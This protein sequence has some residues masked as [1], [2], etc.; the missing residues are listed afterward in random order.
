MILIESPKQKLF[1]FGF[2]Y[3][4]GR[5]QACCSTVAPMNER[6]P[7]CSCSYTVGKKIPEIISK[8]NLVFIKNN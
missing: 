6:S 5:K 1:S 4:R 7:T 2:P 3:F 8:L